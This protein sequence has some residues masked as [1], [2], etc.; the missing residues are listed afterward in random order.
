[1]NGVF[2]TL[3]I[4]LFAHP[5]IVP[6]RVPGAT[7]KGLFYGGGFDQLIG[8]AVGVGATA[9]YVCVVSGIAWLLLKA[10]M[11]IRVSEEEE[12][13]GLDHGE[14]GN[15]AYHGFQMVATPHG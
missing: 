4:G 5:D 1:M 8:Q 15:E 6:L 10:T 12:H 7:W 11:G 9:V 3:C 14:H 13:T 2:G